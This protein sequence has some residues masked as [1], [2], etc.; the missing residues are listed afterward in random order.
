MARLSRPGWLWSNTKMVYPR[1]VTHPSTNR[2][3]RRAT[4]L[5]KTNTLPLSQAASCSRPICNHLLPLVGL[6][7]ILLSMISCS[8]PLCLK[9]WPVSVASIYSLLPHKL[10]KIDIMN[11][12]V[13]HLSIKHAV[14]TYCLAIANIPD[15]FPVPTIYSYNFWST[16][17]SINLV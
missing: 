13:L 10:K 15:Q 9:I 7:F 8:G 3:Q 16:G 1:T 12:P 17:I 6:P 2:A 5:I 11:I 14:L 4:T